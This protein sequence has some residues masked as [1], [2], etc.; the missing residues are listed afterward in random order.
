MFKTNNRFEI[1]T[2]NGWEDFKGIKKIE[3]GESV[4]V[5][6]SDGNTTYKL[7][8]SP[9]HKI[10]TENDWIELQWVEKGTKVRAFDNYATG[11]KKNITNFYRTNRFYTYSNTYINYFCSSRY[12]K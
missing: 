8:G 11:H 5:F 7:S 2:P 4:T 3:R 12:F 9:D 1:K 6:S 10:K